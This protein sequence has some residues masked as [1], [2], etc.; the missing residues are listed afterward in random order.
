MSRLVGF[1]FIACV[2]EFALGML[3][4]NVTMLTGL[5]VATICWNVFEWTLYRYKDTLEVS[6]S[7]P[8]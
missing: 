1:V 4:A 7:T 8:S 3:M 2:M 6:C 5:V